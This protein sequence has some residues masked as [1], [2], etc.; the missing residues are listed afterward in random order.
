MDS[1]DK[2]SRILGLCKCGV[3]LSVNI[4]R[5]LYQS[6]E[7]FLRVEEDDE[8]PPEIDSDVRRVMIETDTVLNLH[9]YPTTPVGYYSIWHYDLDHLLD[10]ALECI[11]ADSK[12]KDTKKRRS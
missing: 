12:W 5:D 10:E 7:Y 3:R 2:L 6:A 1:T 4:H 8:C 9:F 11:E